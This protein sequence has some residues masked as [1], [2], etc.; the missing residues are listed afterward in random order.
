MYSAVTK[1]WLRMGQFAATFVVHIKD[2]PQWNVEGRV[3][4]KLT[5]P[6]E[7][8]EVP[9]ILH[10][11]VYASNPPCANAGLSQQK[12]VPHCS[13]ATLPWREKQF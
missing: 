7:M 3:A 9:G 11:N 10:V 6:S 1:V 2:N 5:L 8:E 12:F 4:V 13:E